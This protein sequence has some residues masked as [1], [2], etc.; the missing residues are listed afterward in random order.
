MV[1]LT[2]H[3]L[4]APALKRLEPG[5]CQDRSA[6]RMKSFLPLLSILLLV[7]AGC[8]RF[9]SDTS[10]T[11]ERARGGEFRVGW[12]E[13]TGNEAELRA[14]LAGLGRHV[15]GRA[16]VERG[17]GEPL[18]MRL[19]AGELDLVVGDFDKESPWSSRVAFSRP[20]KT[21]EHVGGVREARAAVRN[22]EHRWS[23][24]VDQIISEGRA[25]TR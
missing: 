1:S 17:A 18:L 5:L 13:G 4:V 22:G 3:F 2:M 24:I 9:P 19:E 16:R 20:L 25:A 12:I 23:M 7:A 15:R 11:S 21:E 8:D 10:G 14:L 6:S